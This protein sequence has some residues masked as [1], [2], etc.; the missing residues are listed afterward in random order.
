MGRYE[1]GGMTSDATMKCYPVIS[2]DGL[3]EAIN[4]IR[5][6]NLVSKFRF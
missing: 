2:L 4:N 6:V 1:D 3:N 5:E